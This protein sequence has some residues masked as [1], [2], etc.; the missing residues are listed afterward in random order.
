MDKAHYEQLILER[1]AMAYGDDYYNRTYVVPV[2]E[3]ADGILYLNVGDFMD[4]K[5]ERYAKL[6]ELGIPKDY[7]GAQSPLQAWRNAMQELNGEVIDSPVF[8]LGF[9]P[10]TVRAWAWYLA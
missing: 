8:D 7:K 10:S 9:S 2:Y 6:L 3:D 4:S 5:D 1:K